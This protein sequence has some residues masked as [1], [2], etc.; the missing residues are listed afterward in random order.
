MVTSINKKFYTKKTIPDEG[1]C[2]VPYFNIKNVLPGTK[3]KFSAASD[4]RINY[5]VG[6]LPVADKDYWFIVYD[7]EN[8][9]I[10]NNA[11]YLDGGKIMYCETHEQLVE[12]M[13]SDCH[14]GAFLTFA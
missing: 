13:N 1:E 2:F 3:L 7:K 10:V 9:A 4:S 12:Y 14:A 6:K 5:I 11:F 8:P